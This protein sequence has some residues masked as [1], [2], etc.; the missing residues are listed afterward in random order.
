MPGGIGERP[1]SLLLDVRAPARHTCPSAGTN[2]TSAA[3]AHLDRA[4]AYEAEGSKFE[5]CQ[6][7]QVISEVCRFFDGDLGEA[8]E[9][10][11]FLDG[12]LG[13]A[14]EVSRFLDGDLGEAGGLAAAERAPETDGNVGVSQWPLESGAPARA[15]N[16]A[17]DRTGA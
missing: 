2:C 7:H 17:I 15:R 14:S 12:D 6:P 13:E 5:S 16:Q 9:V 8:S 10:S 4:S 11:R 1:A 3:V